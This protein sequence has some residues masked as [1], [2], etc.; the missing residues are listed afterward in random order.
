MTKITK[1]VRKGHRPNM[2]LK[3]DDTLLM[4]LQGINYTNVSRW[5]NLELKALFYHNI[6]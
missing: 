1:Q 5:T 3:T 2:E 4:I 6:S